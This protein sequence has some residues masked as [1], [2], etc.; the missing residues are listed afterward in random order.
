M[1]AS[2][3]CF[4]TLAHVD[5]YGYNMDAMT[6]GTGVGLPK[7]YESSYPYR[8][9]QTFEDTKLVLIVKGNEARLYYPTPA[10]N[11]QT[12]LNNLRQSQT[13]TSTWTFDLQGYSGGMVRSL[14]F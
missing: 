4:D 6:G 10:S 5:S 1:D 8:K 3:T 11:R 2:T 12:P 14:S 13:A 7:E 9:G